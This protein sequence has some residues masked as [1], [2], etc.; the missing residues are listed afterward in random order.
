MSDEEEDEMVSTRG[1]HT[2]MRATLA[3]VRALQPSEEVEDPNMPDAAS[4]KRR[5]SITEGLDAAADMGGEKKF[6]VTVSIHA[7]VRQR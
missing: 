7:A 4:R 2:V 3:D 6:D 1:F 5:G